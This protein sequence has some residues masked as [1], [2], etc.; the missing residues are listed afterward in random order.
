LSVSGGCRYGHRR[1]SNKLTNKNMDNNTPKEEESTD[2]KKKPPK[3][4]K[5]PP[6]TEGEDEEKP[7]RPEL[8]DK[9]RY[10]FSGETADYDSE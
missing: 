2:K 5:L 7:T 4:E 8:P 10:G 1:R 3:I 6:E 9:G